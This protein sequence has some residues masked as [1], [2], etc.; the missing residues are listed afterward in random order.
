MNASESCWF[1][2]WYQSDEWRDNEGKYIYIYGH[3][4]NLSGQQIY[5]K[6]SIRLSM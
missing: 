3:N 1:G 5:E 2:A 4:S 6:E